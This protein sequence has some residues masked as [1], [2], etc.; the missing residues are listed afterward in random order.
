MSKSPI[1]ALR[2]TTKT[3]VEVISAPETAVSTSAR[4]MTGDEY[5]ESIRDGR[6]V[7]LSLSETQSD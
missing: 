7:Y 4:P 1:A 2:A 3:D 5:I 6:E